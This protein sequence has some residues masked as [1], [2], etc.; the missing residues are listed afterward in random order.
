M[1]EIIREK[2]TTRSVLGYMKHN[3]QFLCYTLENA[4]KCIP[5]GKY[6]LAMTYS[7]K[8][9]KLM[10][11]ILNVPNRTGIRIHSG[12]I[13]EDSDGC[14]LVGEREFGVDDF[15]KNSKITLAKIL[16]I[17]EDEKE[18]IIKEGL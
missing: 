11:E 1:I 10:P 6:K 7:S 9:K 3:N 14:I 2:K 13:P 4:S 15:I 17:L 12:N 16:P 5:A 18:I 8:F